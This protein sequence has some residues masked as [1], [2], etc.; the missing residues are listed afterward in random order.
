MNHSWRD[1]VLN[2]KALTKIQS[3]IMVVVIIIAVLAAGSAYIL[4]GG[5]NPLSDTIKIG[6]LADLDGAIGRHVW[7]SSVLAAEQL[8]AEGGILGRQIVVIGEDSDEETSRDLTIISSALTRLLTLHDVDFVLGSGSGEKGYMIQ[9]LSAEHK[10]ILISYGGSEEGLT[11]RVIDDYD[12]YKYYFRYMRGNTTYLVGNTVNNFLHIGEITGFNNVGYLAD[13]SGWNA[14][15]REELDY[16]LPEVYG[17]NLVYKGKFPPFNT[18]DFSSY[19]AAA[20][21]AEA[22]ILFQKVFMIVE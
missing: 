20:E 15:I 12:K 11:Q 17:F 6:I 19:F 13:D 10:K 4:F 5:Q 16:M 8:N 22:E 18:V 3:I 7:Q 21:E 1:V 14:E 2:S 9:G